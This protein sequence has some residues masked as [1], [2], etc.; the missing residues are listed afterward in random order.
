VDR[1]TVDEIKRYFGVVTE[2]LR[3]EIRTVAEGLQGFRDE[4]SAEFRMVRE[5]IGEVKA[6][7]LAP[8]A[9]YRQI[10]RATVGAR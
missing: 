5:E 8:D 2:E 4:V 6:I 10:T 1:E 3:S 7:D 9:L